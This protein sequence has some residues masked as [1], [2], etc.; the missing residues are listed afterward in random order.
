MKQKIV[1]VFAITLLLFTV[2]MI[3]RDLFHKPLS[4]TQASC[5]GDDYTEFKKIDTALLGY[6]K[7]K[8]IE[9]GLKG[10][11]GLTTGSDDNIY[12]CS[13]KAVTVFDRSGTIL[14]SFAIDS[15]AACIALGEK[16]IYVGTGPCVTAYTMSGKKVLTTETYNPKGFITSLAVNGQNIYLADAVSKRILKYTIDGKIEKVIGAKDS[17]TGDPGF[18]IPSMYFDIAFGAF[19][20][21]WAVNPGRL[22]IENYTTSGYMQSEWGKASYENGGF[23]GCCNPA[24][25]ALLP[26][27][28]FVTYEKGLDK[29]KVFDPT[30][31]FICL[32]AGAGSFKGNTDFQLG[33][34]N[35]VKDI[36]TG[37]DGRIYVLDAYNQIV[38][39]EKKDQ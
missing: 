26:D 21:L 19:N 35:L 39:F 14:S 6:M 20:D 12:V 7:Y 1:I 11:T 2:Y 34:N 10:L 5:C 15:A 9:T 31:A 8:T 27:G 37:S 38:I 4:L 23:T 16:M 22:Q 18:I 3:A 33:N 28:K 29:I 25:I 36:A 30:G 32:V 13:N 24:H 17:I